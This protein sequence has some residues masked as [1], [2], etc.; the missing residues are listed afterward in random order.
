MLNLFDPRR[1]GGDS[2]SFLGTDDDTPLSGT[3][4][5]DIQ[6][7]LGFLPENISE[8]F[9]GTLGKKTPTMFPDKIVSTV[10]L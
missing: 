10:G 8:V 7:V 6:C 5:R 4:S 3:S 2:E 1:P 9:Q